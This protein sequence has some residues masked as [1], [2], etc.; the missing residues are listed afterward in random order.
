MSPDTPTPELFAELTAANHAYVEGGAHRSVPVVPSRHLAVVTCMDSRID[1]FAVLGLE[2]G[3]AHVVRN[4]GARVTDDV[5]RSL[6]LSSHLLQTR[7]VA[8]IG[9]TECGALDPR[10]TTPDRL[11]ESLGHAPQPRDWGTFTDSREVLRQDADRLLGWP[12]RPNGLTVGAY[13]F[14]VVTGRLE[15]VV[16]PTAADPV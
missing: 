13:L 5:L 8:L 12:D 4:A 10:G 7:S 3:E 14:D 15:P 1:V 11:T 2:L 6:T 16:S 9:H